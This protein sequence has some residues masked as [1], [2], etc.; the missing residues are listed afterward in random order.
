MVKYTRGLLL[1]SK[2]LDIEKMTFSLL[3][4]LS[5]VKDWWESY[6]ERHDGDESTT[7][8]T[9]PTWANFIDAL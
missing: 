5:Y 3:K 1:C 6:W 7:F 8:R 9:K 4:A 2:I